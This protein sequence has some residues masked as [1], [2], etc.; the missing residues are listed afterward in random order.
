MVCRNSKN[1][2]VREPREEGG[3]CLKGDNIDGERGDVGNVCES[4]ERNEVQADIRVEEDGKGGKK[5]DMSSS[6]DEPCDNESDDQFETDS[7][8]DIFDGDDDEELQQARN[9]FKLKKTTSKRTGTDGVAD[10]LR[11]LHKV[12]LVCKE[13]GHNKLNGPQLGKGKSKKI[14]GSG[15]YI[16]PITGRQTMNPG[17]PGEDVVAEGSCK[18]IGWGSGRRPTNSSEWFARQRDSGSS[19]PAPVFQ[20]QAMPRPKAPSK[21]KT[22]EKATTHQSQPIQGNVR[23]TKAALPHSS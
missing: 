9:N 4:S 15:I 17:M 6:D 3:Y 8:E 7:L 2:T 20:Y 18:E 10:A 12:A 5:N 23:S 13:T 1:Q 16:D 14:V 19:V 11:Q 21:S 22:K